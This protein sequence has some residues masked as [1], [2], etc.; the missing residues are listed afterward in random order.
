METYE[1]ELAKDKWLVEDVV[2]LRTEAAQLLGIEKK[3]D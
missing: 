3:K 2:A 1:R